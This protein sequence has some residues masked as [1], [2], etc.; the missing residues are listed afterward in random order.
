VPRATPSTAPPPLKGNAT[1]MGNAV[2]LGL[3]PVIPPIAIPK[4]ASIS[5]PGAT[6]AGVLP[7]R[8]E[9]DVDDKAETVDFEKQ[10]IDREV[11]DA[12]ATSARDP[13]PRAPSPSSA[14]IEPGSIEPIDV[15][16]LST[17]DSTS[18]SVPFETQTNES[19]SFGGSTDV[20]DDIETQAREKIALEPTE[21][22]MLAKPIPAPPPRASAPILTS[23]ARQTPIPP[24]GKPSKPATTPPPTTASQPIKLPITTAPG[25]LPPPKESKPSTTS[26]PSPAC[27]QCEAPMAWVEEHLR[28]YCKSCRMYF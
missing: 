7:S 11:F 8:P 24:P 14:S 16:E 19:P 4:P 21:P 3:P 22:A 13:K 10:T 28:F 17:G 23:A 25:T 18:P 1:M 2:G 27:P 15:S 26:G 6:L 5:K 9:T 20:T 12:A